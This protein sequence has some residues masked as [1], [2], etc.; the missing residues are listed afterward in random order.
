L[1]G[2]GKHH[3]GG[4][5]S[6]EKEQLAMH[7]SEQKFRYLTRK[8]TVG[9]TDGV[10]RIIPESYSKFLDIVGNKQVGLNQLNSPLFG[11]QSSTAVHVPGAQGSAKNLHQ[12][13]YVLRKLGHRPGG[14]CNA[15][16]DI[17]AMAGEVIHESPTPIQSW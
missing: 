7:G 1:A 11:K 16:E 17:M 2:F 4:R 13:F 3:H 10:W 15:V 12:S 14:W 9:V 5:R 6:R 8:M